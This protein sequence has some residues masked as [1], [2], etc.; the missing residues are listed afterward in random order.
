[1]WLQFQAPLKLLCIRSYISRTC[2][3]DHHSISSGF[4]K[5]WSKLVQLAL[6]WFVLKGRL[7]E[8]HFLRFA[9]CLYVHYKPGQ[10]WNLYS[11]K[12][13]RLSLTKKHSVWKTGWIRIWSN[14][15][16]IMR[17]ISFANQVIQC[18]VLLGKNHADNFASHRCPV[19]SLF[20]RLRDWCVE[21]R[22][23]AS[24]LPVT[25]C[26]NAWE[27]SAWF[28]VWCPHNRFT[29]GQNRIEFWR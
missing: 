5:N 14:T 9:T 13:R 10:L 4:I 2:I 21:R 28:S 19:H 23:P 11:S 29:I 20:W 7:H 24:W 16:L 17:I 8:L 1:M 15:Q 26:D 25:C 6:L 27:L 18:D 22:R 3:I 12:L